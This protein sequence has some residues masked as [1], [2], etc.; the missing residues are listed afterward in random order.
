MSIKILDSTGDQLETYN[1]LLWNNELV[2]RKSYKNII[3][4]NTTSKDEYKVSFRS[5][6]KYLRHP[7]SSQFQ[8]QFI[9]TVGEIQIE[10]NKKT[11]N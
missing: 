2:E 1:N 8:S 5:P 10:I 3:N 9:F 4:V 6:K 11:F 7:L